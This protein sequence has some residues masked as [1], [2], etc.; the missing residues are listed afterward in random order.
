MSRARTVA[1]PTAVAIV[2]VAWLASAAPAQEG[3]SVPAP[4]SVRLAPWTG[5]PVTINVATG[6]TT[7]VTFPAPIASIVTTASKETLTLETVGS[8]L[9]LSPLVQHYTGEVFVILASD[10][11]VPLIARAVA[12]DAADLSVRLVTGSA[13][14][15]SKVSGA[16]H[17]GT[18]TWTPLRLMRAMI[19]DVQEPG[20][21]LTR[22]P[23]ASVV[24][25]DSVLVLRTLATWKSPR[26]EGVVLE[27]ENLTEQWLRIA[28]ESLHFPGLLAVHAER[29]SLAPRPTKADDALAAQQKMKLYL[30]RVPE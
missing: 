4:R 21:T 29:E 3:P 20:V 24:Y 25:D 13:A 6:R 15:T 11:Q 8:R 18:S 16:P 1:V 19:L 22:S 27:A 12:D 30:V 5:Q 10:D 2:L 7:A 28:L 14:A 23:H 17:E 26:Y 9:F